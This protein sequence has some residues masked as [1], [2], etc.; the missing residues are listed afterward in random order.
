MSIPGAARSAE[1]ESM[2]FHIPNPGGVT[3]ALDVPVA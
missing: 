3:A 1:R 2:I